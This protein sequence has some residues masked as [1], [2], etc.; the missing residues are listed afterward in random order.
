M[1]G[2][3][4]LYR[5][6][7]KDD[8]D[9]LP[10][11]L[12]RF[13]SAPGGGRAVGSVAVR[14]ASGLL[15]RLAGFPRS[16]DNVPMRLEVVASETQEIWIRRFGD[17]V[18]KSTQRLEGG[19]LVETF[20]PVRLLFRVRGDDRGVRFECQCARLW[21]L[22][23]PLRVSATERGTDCSWEFEV[24]VARVGSYSGSMSPLP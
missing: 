19:L 20:G 18:R 21:A 12:R 24:T 13:H 6:L 8:F 14:R 5:Q 9:R 3:T 15:A 4:V 10:P 16:G 7:L 17:V 2:R 1:V 23:L 22:P 11:A